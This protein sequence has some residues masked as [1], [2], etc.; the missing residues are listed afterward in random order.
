MTDPNV[1][2][3]LPNSPHVY[4]NYLKAEEKVY[5]T[6]VGGGTEAWTTETSEKFARG[7]ERNILKKGKPPEYSTKDI[8]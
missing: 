8:R 2:T 3:P 6:Q 4:Q 7:F 5:G 1:V